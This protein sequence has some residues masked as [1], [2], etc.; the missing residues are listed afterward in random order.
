M[1]PA[2]ALVPIA[3]RAGCVLVAVSVALV[4]LTGFGLAVGLFSI[5]VANAVFLP[6]RTGL[7]YAAGL[8]PLIFVDH[9]WSEP[10]LGSSEPW[11]EP[12]T[13]YLRLCS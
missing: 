5:S 1:E 7:A 11:S 3:G 13:G 10:E 2:G 6:D 12:P 9:L 8:M 4:H